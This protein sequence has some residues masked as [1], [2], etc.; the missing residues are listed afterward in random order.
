MI[1]RPTGPK[2]MRGGAQNARD[3]RVLGH[4]NKHLNDAALHKIKGS[5]G[6]GRI[7]S[8]RGGPPTGPRGQ[9]TR[10]GHMS[11]ARPPR[12]LGAAQHPQRPNMGAMAGAGAGAG[13]L[14]AMTPQQQMQLMAMYE[15]QA[16]MMA[17]I[18]SPQQQQMFPGQMAFGGPNAPQPQQGKSLFERVDTPNGRNG[19]Y[20]KRNNN[21][22]FSKHINPEGMTGAGDP[23]SF[24]PTSSMEVESSQPTKDPSSTICHYN[25]SCTRAD[26]SF[27]HQS[28]AAPIGTSIDMTDTCSYGA[29]CKNRKCVGKHPSPAKIGA[30]KAQADCKFYPNCTNPACPFKHP[31]AAPCRN[32]ADCTVPNCTFAHSKVVCK[33]DPC[34][35]PSCAFKHADGQKR[36]TFQDKVWKGGEHVSDRKFVD[37]AGAEED[38]ILP[39]GETSQQSADGVTASGEGIIA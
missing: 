26:C 16:R 11:Q 14:G 36:G 30:F 8:H 10:G 15:E 12:G 19:Q 34:L 37:E 31:S 2:S 5:A 21:T 23:A 13:G 18:L 28:S 22:N 1:H 39:G 9:A 32:G 17:Q 7:T 29:A 35:N 3:K 38:L 27:V 6:T 4:V 33:F 24:D 25:L 20:N